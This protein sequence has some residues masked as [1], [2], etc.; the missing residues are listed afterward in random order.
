MAV[1]ALLGAAE[2]AAIPG[3]SL[4]TGMFYSRREHALRHGFWFIGNSLGIMLAGIL[5]FGIAH[6]K[7][8]IGAWK[9]CLFWTI[10][11][12]NYLTLPQWLFV[13]LAIITFIWAIVIFWLLP[14]TPGNAK[15]LSEPQKV[16]AVERLRSNQMVVK[17]NDFQWYQFREALLDPRIWL[18]CIYLLCVSIC[19]SS[20]AAVNPSGLSTNE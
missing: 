19:S 1:R 20:I 16:R 6:I 13:A 5:S 12:P 2:A 14:D 11:D 9:V 7:S 18:L 4:L 8:G 10:A 3:F 15:F 17:N